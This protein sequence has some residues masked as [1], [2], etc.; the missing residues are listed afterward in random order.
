MRKGTLPSLVL[1]ATPPGRN[2]FPTYVRRRER[3]GRVARI[4]ASKRIHLNDVFD[5]VYHIV[6]DV[7]YDVL[8]K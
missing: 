5:V 3:A 2:G 1:E 6:Y 8:I 7:L 4:A